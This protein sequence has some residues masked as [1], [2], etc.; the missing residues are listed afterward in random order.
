MKRLNLRT[1]TL[2]IKQ[3]IHIQIKN[4]FNGLTKSLTDM[5]ICKVDC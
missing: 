3:T 5:V 2:T 1:L 4:F